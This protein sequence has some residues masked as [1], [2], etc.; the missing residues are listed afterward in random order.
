MHPNLNIAIRA[1][2]AAGDIIL[3]YHNQ[4]ELLTITNKAA[5]DFVS[6]VDKSAEVAIIDEIKKAFPEHSF[7]AEESGE[8]INDS[9]FLW[10]IDPLDG[11][12]NYLHGFPQYA[13][14]I[15]LFEDG[16]ATQ[17]VVYDPFKEEMFF[18]SRGDGC[19]LN[20][21]RI[22]VSGALGFE[23]TLIGTGFPFRAPE[24]L[25]TYLAMFKA[26]HP[27]VA[28]IRRAGSAAL[29]LAYIASGRLDGFFEIGLN[30][31]D[32]AAGILLIKEAGG[33]I[34]TFK[35]NPIP[36]T[37]SPINVIAATPKILKPLIK[38]INP[39]LTSDLKF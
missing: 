39:H 23:N 29:D 30:I 8:T 13:V 38:I 32:I 9:K 37:Q 5:N 26:I 25:D 36:I 12:T 3:R 16:E 35:G 14:S 7:L 31:W 21:H 11:T 34:T 20:N 18:A 27:K 2:R 22:R 28:G 4:I 10:I 17:A 6:E 1:A 33:H 19:Y 15:A 24:H